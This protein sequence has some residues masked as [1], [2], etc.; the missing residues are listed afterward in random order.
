MKKHFSKFIKLFLI[1]NIFLLLICGHNRVYSQIYNEISGTIQENTVLTKENEPYLI[2]DN[3]TIPEGITLTINDGVTLN[4]A[5]GTSI[6]VEGNL[7]VNG[8]NSSHITFK[9]QGKEKWDKVIIKSDGNII[10]YLD[11]DNAKEGLEIIKDENTVYNVNMTNCR[12]NL[13]FY[14]NDNSENIIPKS[15]VTAVSDYDINKDNKLDILDITCL[16]IYYNVKLGDSGYNSSRDFNKD[17]IINLYD[18][19]ILSQ[20]I[21][22]PSNSLYGRKIFIDPGHG[23]Q[24]PGAVQNGYVEKNVNL[25]LALKLKNELISH[26]AVVV[27]SR[28]SDVTLDLAQRVNMANAA[29]AD[30]LLSIHHNSSTNST[31][32]GMS[33]HYSTY[34]PAIE[35]KDDYVMYNGSKF[36]YISEQNGSIT[37]NYYGTPKTLS[38]SSAD[39]TVYDPTPCSQAVQSKN[40]SQSIVNS[41]SS[42]GFENDGIK[43]HNLYLTRWPKMT[44]VLIEA[45]YL[46]NAAE[47]A[48]VTSSDMELKMAK[49]IANSIGA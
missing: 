49:K 32:I 30:L 33:T 22:A 26:G 18:L 48:K 44:S 16:A 19:V 29:N 15:Y 39:I 11:I 25:S 28:D 17:N 8:I 3:V 14:N 9:S 42:L 31:P 21:G 35:T 6:N 43:D 47:A 2:K 4:F 23:G 38:Y 20:Q 41:L 1:M 12:Y 46:S 24:D 7:F 5:P 27:M 13:N 40:Y 34:R 37:F 45:G 10:R 36:T